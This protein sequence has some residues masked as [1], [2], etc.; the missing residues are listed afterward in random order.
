MV[1]NQDK[2]NPQSPS[3][4]NKVIHKVKWEFFR[5][6]G[7]TKLDNKVKVYVISH[8][9]CGRTWL[10]MILGKI[11]CSQFNLDEKYIL[12]TIK[13]TLEAGVTNIN[14]IHDGS[15]SWSPGSI[16]KSR[17]VRFVTDKSIF[18]DKKVIFLCRNPKDVLVSSYF[19]VTRRYDYQFQGDISDFIRSREHGIKKLVNFYNLWYENQN[20]PEDFL[21]IKYEDLKTAPYETLKTIID[22]AQIK[23]IEEKTI[24]NAIEFA[25]FDNMKNLEKNAKLHNS[26]LQ[27][28]TVEDN[29][30]YKVR[31][32]K[33]GGYLDYLSQEDIEYIDRV[34]ARKGC[35]FC[36]Y[37]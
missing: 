14:W 12:N 22:F 31:R 34:I 32:G 3:L 2:Q 10:R 35:P 20:V 15:G 9:K 30:S 8:P 5:Q 23:N 13:L 18:K 36:L 16:T 6:E 26:I 17:F 33:V 37:K 11:L 7:R 24:K 1:V 19:H 4:L 21:L 27:P 25:K 29:E 28:G